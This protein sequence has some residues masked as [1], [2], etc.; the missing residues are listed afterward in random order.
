MDRR[1]KRAVLLRQANVLFA[2]GRVL[3]E[4]K[5]RCNRAVRARKR[6]GGGD[7]GREETR[8][9]ERERER[10]RGDARERERERERG[11]ASSK[12]ISK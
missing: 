1:K 4:Q 8:E 11:D 5:R 7:G 9:R 10:E 6:G 2:V 3:V 12:I